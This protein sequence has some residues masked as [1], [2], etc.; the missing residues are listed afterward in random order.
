V[1]R[2]TNIEVG[3]LLALVGGLVL[4]VSLFLHWYEPGTSAWNAFEVIDLLL[5]LAAIAAI[6]GGVSPRVDERLL[7]VAGA[8]AVVLVA[9]QLINRP[10]AAQGAGLM[11]GA[12]FALA[13][14]A[15][16]L[17]G[18]IATVAWAV[19]LR[20]SV[21]RRPPPAS[22]PQATPTQPGETQETRELG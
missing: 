3:P 15:L 7:V 4:L 10:P 14:A 5:A 13:G 18:G 6:A 19:S 17:L 9:S 16:M 12:W 8:A 2:R 22:P 1:S 21:D 20:V 11:F